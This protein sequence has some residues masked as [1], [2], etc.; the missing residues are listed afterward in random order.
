MFSTSMTASSTTS[1]IAIA[2]PPSVIVLSVMPKLFSTMTA[3]SNDR[4]MARHEIAAVRMSKRNRNSTTMTKTPPSS[5]ASRT[6]RVATSMKVAGRNSVASSSMPCAASTGRSVASVS[7]TRFVTSCV[8]VPNCAE[9]TKTTPGR[10]MIVAPPI[11]GSGASAIVAT[12]DRTT[13]AA[14][15]VVTTVR[16]TSAAVTACPSL[17]K[18]MRWFGVSRNPA[19]RTAVALREA[20]TTS[21]S[22]TP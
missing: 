22:P 7:S 2:R 20:A 4:G 6:L 15:L 18:M 11:A 3:A 17:R 1:P 10:P 5:S 16:P 21:S 13:L 14:P 9:M 19:P 12:S 8:L